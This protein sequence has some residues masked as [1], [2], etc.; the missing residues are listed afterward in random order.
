[1]NQQ[2]LV[3]T[4]SSLYAGQYVGTPAVW[5][6]TL[7]GET[8][9]IVSPNAAT[10][11]NGAAYW[12]GYGKF[13]KYDGAMTTL[14]CDI[15]K[16]IFDNIDPNQYLQVTC[17]T[18]EQFNEVWWF[19]T[20]VNS[21]NGL[22]DSYAV[23]NYDQD[24]WYYGSLCRTAWLQNGLFQYPV[25]ATGYNTLVYH[26]NGNN[27]NET[28]TPNPMNTYIT[29]SEFDIQDGS[30]TVSY[31]WRILPDFTFE[32]ST[33]TSPQV[34]MSFYPMLNAGSGYYT[35]QSVGNVSGGNITNTAKYPIQQFTGQVN[36]RV[37]GRQI[38]FTISSSQLNLSWQ[39]GMHRFDWKPDGLRG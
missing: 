11:S 21:T 17:G 2:I 32:G 31:I 27:N 4:D 25:G 12:M 39:S 20:S 24:I 33:A 9:S 22:N 26:E 15:K 28:G 23:Y 6:F 35:P 14:R 29:S 13:Y 3:F 1:M 34:S 8:Q 10:Y 7:V 30:G 18:N 36:V 16:Y 5:T 19:Y 38:F 37:R